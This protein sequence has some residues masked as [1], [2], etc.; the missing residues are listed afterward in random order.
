M[1]KEIKKIEE[2]V[3]ELKK[4]GIIESKGHGN[5]E[6]LRL[7]PLGESKS[8]EILKELNSKFENKYKK[9]LNDMMNKG[10]I[11]FKEVYVVTDHFIDKILFHQGIFLSKPEEDYSEA[12]GDN[13]YVCDIIS[14]S[15]MCAIVEQ[16]GSLKEKEIIA[17]TKVILDILYRDCMIQTKKVVYKL[18]N[19]K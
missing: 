2:A 9:H 12:M 13:N 6:W 17:K 14:Y 15:V 5:K 8:N 16:Y 10:I 7:T 18:L 11:G 1:N 3:E 19:I 4:A